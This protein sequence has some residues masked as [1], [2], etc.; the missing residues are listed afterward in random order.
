MSVHDFGRNAIFILDKFHDM[1]SLIFA[2]SEEKNFGQND[3]ISR[4][5]PS[6]SI[7]VNHSLQN[8]F[9]CKKMLHWHVLCT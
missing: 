5:W 8:I 2:V 1:T 3:S 7:F 4:N 6:L 9:L